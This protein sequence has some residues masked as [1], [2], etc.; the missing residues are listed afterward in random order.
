MNQMLLTKKLRT[1][2]EELKSLTL[3]P[4]EIT[5]VEYCPAKACRRLFTA[6]LRGYPHFFCVHAVLHPEQGSNIRITVGLPIDQWNGK[7]LGL[8]NGGAAGKT[9]TTDVLRGIVQGYA[10]VH[11]DMGTSNNPFDKVE[12]AVLVDFGY[13]ATHLMTVTAKKIIEV[14]YGRQPEHSYFFGSSTGGQQALKEAQMY[15]EDYDGILCFCPACD[16]VALHTQ[17]TWSLDHVHGITARITKE[18]LQAVTNRLVLEY[19]EVCGGAPGDTFLSYTDQ[20][21]QIDYS[22]FKDSKME[23][24]LSDEK[25]EM[26]KAVYAGPRDPETGEF[27]YEGLTPGAETQAL[28]LGD[29]LN[30]DNFIKAL[31]FPFY[32]GYGKELDLLSFDFHRDYTRAKEDLSPI[33]DAVNPDLG[34]FRDNGGKLIIIHGTADAAICWTSSLHYYRQ[35]ISQ[36][37]SLE[38]TLSFFRYF[39]VPGLAHGF[40]GPGFQDIGNI[41]YADMPLNALHDPLV[42]LDEWVT[43]A[44][45]PEMLLASGFVGGNL[46]KPVVEKERPVYPY[47]LRTRYV[48]GDPNLA[49]SFE[50]YLPTE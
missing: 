24:P 11:T 37:N 21:P 30:A 44:N 28:S 12:K 45:A 41:D 13:R 49:S 32:W 5:R 27:I 18:E 46:L 14:F 23:I 50:P 16:R 15:P 39:L 10:T 20:I 35:V 9:G 1:M 36:N 48:S 42:A 22:I 7:L 25:I 4:G 17:F 26:L 31:E 2:K 8:G 34:P 40:G 6:K 43:N 19:A 3:E 29:M 47:P 38:N 33:L